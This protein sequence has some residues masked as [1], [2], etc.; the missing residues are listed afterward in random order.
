MSKGFTLVEL[1]IGITILALLSVGLL[2]ALDPIEQVNRGRDSSLNEIAATVSNAMERFRA[3]NN[4]LP[5]AA[6][7]AAENASY[8]LDTAAAANTV[9][10]ALVNSGELKTNFVTAA[11][12][13]LASILVVR[14]P[15]IGGQWG[16]TF[17]CFKPQS[18]NFKSKAG[19]YYHLDA[20]GGNG[21]RTAFVGGVAGTGDVV[22]A[23]APLAFTPGPGP[24]TVCQTAMAAGANMNTANREYCAVCFVQ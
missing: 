22:Q 4:A 20:F 1:I 13:N 17:V 12:A 11:G 18:K 6:S 9:L 16:N 21:I 15:N 19:L 5:G 14:G 3:Q 24:A 10:T 7:F 2:A 8:R 23:A